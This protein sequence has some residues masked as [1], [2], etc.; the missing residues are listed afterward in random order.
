MF[1]Y[2]NTK[3]FGGELPEVVLSFVRRPKVAGHFAPERWDSADEGQKAH[4]IFINPTE[5]RRPLSAAQTIV[6]EMVHL[7]QHAFGKPARKSYHDKEWA[8]KMKEVG[9]QPSSTG[10]PGG[11]ETGQHMSDYPLPGGAFEV[12][13][14]KMPKTCL[15]PWRGRPEAEKEKSTS[16]AGS[17]K[18]KFTCP[19]CDANAWGK[20]ELNLVCGDC[21]ETMESAAKEAE[22]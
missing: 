10:A 11:K 22:S 8:K 21:D 15:L 3:L 4:E 16:A 7:W 6:H 12:A 14:K 9:L 19:G 17:S 13:F 20:P 5:F 2:F 1:D 18:T